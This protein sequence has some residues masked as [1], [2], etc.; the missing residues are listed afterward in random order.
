M[1]EENAGPN[2][3]TE[4][5]IMK[6]V[7]GKPDWCW[8]FPGPFSFGC[9]SRFV[10]SLFLLSTPKTIHFMREKALFSKC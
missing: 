1:T 8:N 6:L 3:G 9:L 7:Q 10:P 4:L 2:C 5:E